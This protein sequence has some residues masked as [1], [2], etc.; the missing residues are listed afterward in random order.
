MIKAGWHADIGK[1]TLVGFEHRLDGA[2]GIVGFNVPSAFEMPLLAERLGECRQFIS[3]ACAALVVDGGIHRHDF[4]APAVVCGPVRARPET[5]VPIHSVSLTPRY[6][7]PTPDHA[8][9]VRA[10]FVKT[11]AV[12][13]EAVPMIAPLAPHARALRAKHPRARHR[14]LR[15]RSALAGD[16][17]ATGGAHSQGDDSALAAQTPSEQLEDLK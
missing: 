17:M 1:Q 13:A 3:I 4:V 6:S 2:A 5:G 7:Q 8:A 14:C 10:H 15:L 11:G 16:K 12:A 9:V